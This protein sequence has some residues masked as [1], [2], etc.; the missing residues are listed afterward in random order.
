MQR[1]Q[2]EREVMQLVQQLRDGGLLAIQDHRGQQQ[3]DSPNVD[4]KK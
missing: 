1:G 2:V 4:F 3:Q